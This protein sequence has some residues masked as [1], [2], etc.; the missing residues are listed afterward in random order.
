MSIAITISRQLGSGGDEIAARLAERLDIPVLDREIIARAAAQAGVSEET[1]LEAER[2]PTIMDRMLQVLG[3]PAFNWD[4]SLPGPSELLLT[5]TATR[6]QYHNLVE[7]IIRNM[8]GSGSV[9]IADRAG[10]MVL[11]DFHPALHVLIIAPIKVRVDRLMGTENLD[12]LAAEN[13]LLE[14]DQERAN[15]FRGYYRINGDD[16][17]LYHM[18]LNTG[19]MDLATCVDLIEAAAR[20]LDV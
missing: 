20:R 13:R 19:L 15:Y 7:E 10:Q 2:V 17:S 9:I 12:K 3:R 16:P 5:S 18:S 14:A 11:S 4:L 1:I 6:E 8:A